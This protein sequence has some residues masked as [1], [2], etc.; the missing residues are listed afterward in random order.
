MEI[1]YSTFQRIPIIPLRKIQGTG[2][3]ADLELSDVDVTGTRI[4][5]DQ[6]GL[7]SGSAGGIAPCLRIMRSAFVENCRFME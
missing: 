1:E 5:L 7:N 2:K 4:F 3:G 6:V